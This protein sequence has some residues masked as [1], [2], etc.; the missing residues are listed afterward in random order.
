METDTKIPFTAGDV[1][2][3]PLT[4]GPSIARNDFHRKL[5][6]DSPKP[7]E[8]FQGCGSLELRLEL[9]FEVLEI[10]P[11]ATTKMRAR[12]LPSTRTGNQ[13]LENLRPSIIRS[14]LDDLDP[15]TIT[16]RGSGH[17][18]RNALPAS[19]TFTA[20]HQLLNHDLQL[21]DLRESGP[22]PRGL[23]RTPR[24]VLWARVA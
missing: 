2:L 10:A 23:F 3:S 15:Q 24:G 12:W 18:D 21:I 9:I 8:R 13:N 7:R 14:P 5:H 19:E 17:E 11:T 20:S 6:S 1:N 16:W 4:V 22:R